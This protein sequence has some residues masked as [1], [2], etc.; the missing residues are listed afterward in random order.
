MFVMDGS[1]FNSRYEV[2]PVDYWGGGIDRTRE[3]ED[4]VFSRDASIPTD[5]IRLMHVFLKSKDEHKSPIV[6][7]VLLI[8]KT[9]GLPC[10]LYSDEKAWRL[11]DTRRALPVTA[12]MD[13]LKGAVPI[14]PQSKYMPTNYIEP[15]LELVYKKTKE[16]LTPRADKLRYLLIYYTKRDIQY[17]DEQKVGEQLNRELSNARK[18]DNTGYKTAAKLI[19]YLRVNKLSTTDFVKA[20]VSKW[21]NISNP[22]DNK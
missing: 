13:L 7:Q 14:K 20:M 10:Y 21:D 22:P 15:W 16:E 5:S 11:L 12:D 3:T 18:P 9:A 4:R 8:A 17:G 6:R 2:K 1:W 19:K